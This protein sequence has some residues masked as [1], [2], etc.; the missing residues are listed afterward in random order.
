M[1]ARVVARAFYEDAYLDF[2][3]QYYLAMGFD[4][5]VILKAD[6]I[7]IPN[8]EKY[9][10]GK[11]QC[12][13]VD[14][15]GNAILNKHISYYMDQTYDWI[16]NID[17]DEFLVI[18]MEKFPNI[19]AYLEDIT[20]RLD[21]A[22]IMFWWICINKLTCWSPD[23]QEPV[24]MLDY[25]NGDYTLDFYKYVKSMARPSRVK[26]ND[27]MCHFYRAPTIE[28][29]V[30]R[31]KTGKPIIQ[32][33]NVKQFVNI[34]DGLPAKICTE[35]PAEPSSQ[36]TFCDGFI[37]HLN[38]RSLTNGLTKS[39]VT[40]LHKTKHFKNLNTFCRYINTIPD[41]PDKITVKHRTTLETHMDGKIKN[42]KRILAYGKTMASRVN[43]AYA[44][45]QLDSI[46]KHIPLI[47]NTPI[48]SIQA[49]WDIIDKLAQE[50][51]INPDKLRV[52]LLG[53][54]KLNA[55]NGIK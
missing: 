12:I 45:H 4:S 23:R 19:Q 42:P 50:K 24:T 7:P 5:V 13:S 35:L 40:K 3:I 32:P 28:K 34:L 20:T 21:P 48:M 37:L 52:L 27:I 47:T 31:S 16:L 15:T 39:L 11:V 46:I 1:K 10:E 26:Q 2:F 54:S 43:L 18:D 33:P 8:M 36:K 14:N 41:S 9:P 30:N 38:S 51:K 6:G 49:E 53:V 29:A 25:I 44:R 17:A 55:E 22:Q